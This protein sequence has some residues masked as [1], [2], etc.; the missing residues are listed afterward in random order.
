MATSYVKEFVYTSAKG[1]TKSR[2]LWVMNETDDYVEGLDFAYLSRNEQAAIKRL[3]K[4]HKVGGVIS[5]PN[6][7]ATPIPG[8]KANWNGA[9]RKFAKKNFTEN[10]M[11]KK[12][13]LNFFCDSGLGTNRNSVKAN[14]CAVLR[15]KTGRKTVYGY[16]IRELEKNII[17]VEKVKKSNGN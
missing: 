11:T 4:N 13:L 7:G 8:Y 1:E 6:S 9:W 15:G 5:K 14:V 3:L 16:N 2:K 12:Q 17:I 10:A